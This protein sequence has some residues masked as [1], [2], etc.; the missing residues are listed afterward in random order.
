LYR[1]GNVLILMASSW[2]KGKGDDP[3]WC[4][5]KQANEKGWKIR[6][7]EKSTV[8]EYWKFPEPVINE[9]QEEIPAEQAKP[10]VFYANVFHA[11]QVEGIP[12]YQSGVQPQWEPNEYAERILLQSE[13]RIYHDQDNRAYYTLVK[14]EIH[15]PPLAA[16]SN[17]EAY[18]STALHE[19]GHW[20][21][22]PS[23]LNRNLGNEFGSEDYAREELR[24]EM[25]SLFIAIETGVPFDPAQHAA[26]NRS[27]ISVLKNDRNEFFRATADAERIAEYVIGLAIEKEQSKLENL[28]QTN[29]EKGHEPLTVVQGNCG[30]GILQQKELDHERNSRLASICAIKLQQKHKVYTSAIKEYRYQ[31]HNLIKECGQTDNKSLDKIVA[32]RMLKQGYHQKQAIQHAISEASPIAAGQTNAKAYARRIVD[33]A[34]KSPEVLKSAAISHGL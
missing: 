33:A 32:L 34:Q 2:R 29:Q 17:E 22:H 25:A 1:G 9:Q 3:R 6:K 28:E 14:D 21:G 5:F 7:G 13:A 27:W 31:A 30:Q 18:Y 10:Q 20:T 8:V 26:Y 23:R 4:T 15:L 12:P 19:L 16:F 11:S 24:A